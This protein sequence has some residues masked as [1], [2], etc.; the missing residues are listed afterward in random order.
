M[1]GNAAEI[2]KKMVVMRFDMNKIK[3]LIMGIGA[4]Q[5]D[6]FYYDTDIIDLAL[7]LQEEYHFQVHVLDPHAD[8]EFL[9]KE[10]NIRCENSMKGFGVVST[11]SVFF[12]AFAHNE[13]IYPNFK[14]EEHNRGKF[15]ICDT[16]NFFPDNAVALKL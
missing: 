8:K 15:I 9:R 16:K 1:S 14:I 10:Y 5:G 6:D 11:Y 13:F 7:E 2:V 3:V 4:K 12:L